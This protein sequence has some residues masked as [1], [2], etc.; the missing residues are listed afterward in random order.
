MLLSVPL[1]GSITFF[2]TSL[3]IFYHNSQRMADSFYQ[4]TESSELHEKKRFQNILLWPC[5]SAM[6]WNFC[7]GLHRYIVLCPMMSLNLI[8]HV[9]ETRK[10]VMPILHRKHGLLRGKAQPHM[11]QQRVDF[12]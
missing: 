12:C 9:C 2:R 8:S 4:I 1:A 7:E 5:K 11:Y 3:I 6:C 10:F